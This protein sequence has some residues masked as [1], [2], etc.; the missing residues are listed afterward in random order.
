MKTAYFGSSDRAGIDI[1]FNKKQSTIY[2]SG[3]YDSCVGIEGEE[4]SL[5]E[6]F[7]KCG[8]TQKDCEKAFKDQKV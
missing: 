5:K 7:E 8:I 1:Q 6:F 4:L 2:I 3:W